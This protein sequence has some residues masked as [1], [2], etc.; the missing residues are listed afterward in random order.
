ML[1]DYSA[2]SIVQ[3]PRISIIELDFQSNV[4]VSERD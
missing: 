1:S 4:K 2:L 3:Q